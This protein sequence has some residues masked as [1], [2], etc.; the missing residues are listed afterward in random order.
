MMGKRSIFNNARITIY[1]LFRD[2]RCVY[3]GRTRD[4]ERRLVTHRNNFGEE[5]A[6]IKP[7]I[8]KEVSPDKASI[9]EWKTIHEYKNKGE[10]D[11]NKEPSQSETRGLGMYA[12]DYDWFTKAA[13]LANRSRIRMIRYV[14]SEWKAGRSVLL[15]IEDGKNGSRK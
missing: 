9:E 5:F 2:D 10:A 4:L 15:T 11:Y 13:Q 12:D 8:L 7:R 6:A 3:V 1:G 14:I